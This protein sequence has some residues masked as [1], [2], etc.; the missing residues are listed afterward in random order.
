MKSSTILAIEPEVGEQLLTNEQLEQRFGAEIIQKVA[1]T[2]GIKNRRVAAPGTCGSD[3][4]YNAA[5]RLL[6]RNDVDPQSIDLLIFCTQSPDYWLPTTACIL[7][8]RLKLNSRC[9]AFDINLGCTQYVYGLSVA[10]S[11]IAAGCATRALVLTGDTMTHTINPKDRALVP[12]MGDAGSA[13]LLE[14]VEEGKGFLGFELGTDGS[15][16]Q[17]LMIPAGGARHPISPETSIETEDI[18]GNV[19]TPENLYMNGVAI[20]HF[21][22]SVVPKAIQSLLTKVSLGMEDVDLFLF[23]QANKF[24]IDHLIKKLKIPP[25]KTHFYIENVGNTSGSTLPLLMADAH[26]A[27]KLKPRSTVLAAAFGVGLSWGAT[28]MKWGGGSVQTISS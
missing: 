6:D 9:A 2:V 24:M 23:H 26:R 4:A 13:T 21:A 25:T 28:V 3:L 10:H 15:G 7:Q 8:D 16:H 12:L 20:F 5:R 18:D 17:Y 1:T 19:R 22:L 11:M 14:A 27:G